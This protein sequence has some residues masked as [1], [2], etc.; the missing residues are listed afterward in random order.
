MDMDQ[1]MDGE[2]GEYDMEG[3]ESGEFDMDPMNPF[4]D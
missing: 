4:E 2:S 1:L 3:D